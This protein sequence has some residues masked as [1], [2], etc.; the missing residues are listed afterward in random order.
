[1][2]KKIIITQKE[3]DK[4]ASSK[5]GFFTNTLEGY[6]DSIKHEFIICS[7]LYKNNKKV[8]SNNLKDS[9]SYTHFNNIVNEINK[10]VLTIKDY[11]AIARSQL[12]KSY[13]NSSNKNN[14]F[15]EYAMDLTDEQRS[16]LNISRMYDSIYEHPECPEDSV[17]EDDDM[18]DGW[19]II[20]RKNNA[21][22]KKQ[23]SLG[24]NKINEANEVFIVT[25]N[26]EDVASIVDL[27]TDENKAI[28]MEKLKYINSN[29]NQGQVEDF[30]LPDVQRDLLTKARQLRKQ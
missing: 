17:I 1:M 29:S 5:Q 13:W 30:N 2:R 11:K 19:M 18:L 22:N 24:N 14:I 16:L 28:L 21:K 20:Q 12:W 25:D 26:T 27:N 8:F 15:C 6:A 7:T 9:A 23:K 3:I 4:I 10:Y